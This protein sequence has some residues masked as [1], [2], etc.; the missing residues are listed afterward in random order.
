MLVTGD[1]MQIVYTF[2]SWRSMRDRCTVP[3]SANYLSYGG[4]GIIVCER[5]LE[6]ADNFVVDMGIKP[7]GTSLERLDVNGN[8][9]PANCQWATKKQQAQNRRTSIALTHNGETKNVAE[10]AREKGMGVSTLIGRHHSGM[11]LEKALG[12][13][14][15]TNA[16]ERARNRKSNVLVTYDGKTQCMIEWAEEINIPVKTLWHRKSLG[17]SDEKIVT[18]PTHRNPDVPKFYPFP[19]ESGVEMLNLS[20]IARRTNQT[21]TA[22]RVKILDG[23]SPEVVFSNKKRKP[24]R[25]K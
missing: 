18:T 10:W 17:W 9:E 12:D 2:G 8:Y 16:K 5:W 24:K 4:R 7:V 25:C 21:L 11:P 3:S 13:K 20:E 6:S 14:V 15:H 22:V 23:E 1:F 19:T